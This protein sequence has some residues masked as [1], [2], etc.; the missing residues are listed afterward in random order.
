MRQ[1]IASLAIL[2]AAFESGEAATPMQP[3][4]EAATVLIGLIAETHFRPDSNALESFAVF[5]NWRK[6][7][8]AT[9]LMLNAKVGYT[10]KIGGQT[11]V[12]GGDGTNDI[13]AIL[14]TKQFDAAKVVA[15]LSG[16]YKLKKQ[17]TEDS[18]GERF[19]TYILVD[20]GVQV[21][22]LTLTYGVAKAVQGAGT[23]AFM[24]KDRAN[25]ELAEHRQDRK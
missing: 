1:L 3:S 5:N 21:G 24:A 15:E 16:V 7:S 23:I 2:I 20:H 17:D 19:D 4:N 13:F 11:A 18:D 10:G 9:N 22:I 6:T 25:R 8:A 12:I 14:L